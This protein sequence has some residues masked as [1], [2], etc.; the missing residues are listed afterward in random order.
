MQHAFNCLELQIKATMQLTTTYG[1]LRK[2]TLLNG[3]LCCG[4]RTQLTVTCIVPGCILWAAGSRIVR[5]IVPTR[6]SM[7]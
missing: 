7:F 3:A 1:S 2:L 4:A 6:S 5:A